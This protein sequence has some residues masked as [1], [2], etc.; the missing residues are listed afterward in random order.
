MTDKKDFE[1]LSH[2]QSD[3][4]LSYLH[5][6]NQL[7]RDEWIKQRATE[8]KPGS[9]VLDVGA[10]TCPYR[11]LF[12]HCEYKTHD[13][14]QY[15]GVKLGGSNNYGDIDFVSDLTAIPVPDDS[16]DVV[17]CTEVLEHVPDP[18]SALKEMSRITKPGGLLILTAPLGSGLH[19][20]P[21]HFYGGFTPE[22]YRYFA[23]INGLEVKE[24]KA[25]G[26]FFRMLAQESARV[27]WLME[28]H[29]QFHGQNVDA[30]NGLFGEAL[31]RFL[32]ALEDKLFIDQFT[33]GYNVLLE[34]K[35]NHANAST[36]SSKPF[37]AIS[38]NQISRSMAPNEKVTV[39]IFSKDRPMQLDA[40]LSSLYRCCRD[41]DSVNVTVIYKSTSPE[42]TSGYDSLKN[43]YKAKFI[44]EKTFKDDL[45]GAIEGS[46]YLLFVVDDCIFI[47]EFSISDCVNALVTDQQSIG[48][49]LRLGRNTRYC[50]TLDKLQ[51][52]PRFEEGVF[53]LLK[54][55]WPNA[56]YDFGYPLELSSSLY[57]L[58][59]LNPILQSLQFTAPNNLEDAL[60]RN[61]ARFL[62][63]YPILHCFGYSVAFCAPMNRVQDEYLN[64]TSGDKDLSA[65]QL[66]KM[67]N[68]GFRIDVQAYEQFIPNACHQEVK[69]NFY[70]K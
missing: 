11:K 41:I 57:R 48:V 6:F 10:G 18:A 3:L 47:R 31:P 4:P 8:V 63:K 33:I 26:G 1:F 20:L 25:N 7:D 59:D 70:K 69:M 56:D 46:G 37:G 13:F 51:A 55:S 35:L 19:Q 27:S 34:K 67:F 53:G 68:D 66:M 22:W 65:D 61:A 17:I 58:Q 24:I 39:I 36:F 29:W 5:N 9:R 45:L 40:T 23:G 2:L 44:E 32:F 52:I 60:S 21:F 42:F 14:K 64:R 49:S 43:S 38:A 16:F 62:S 50:Y 28:K 15:E 54:Y 12:S 30:V